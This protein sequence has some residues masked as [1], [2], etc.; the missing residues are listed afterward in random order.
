MKVVSRIEG[1]VPVPPEGSNV[2]VIAKLEHNISNESGPHKSLAEIVLVG[3]QPHQ[4]GHP[5]PVKRLASPFRG[6]SFHS[7][8]QRWRSRIKHGSKSEH[9]GYFCSDVEAAHAYN[10]AAKKIHGNNAQLNEGVELVISSHPSVS[11]SVVSNTRV[12]YDGQTVYMDRESK[13]KGRQ[14]PNVSPTT[15]KA[16]AV[17]VKSIKGRPQ[18]GAAHQQAAPLHRHYAHQSHVKR[19]SIKHEAPLD[20]YITAEDEPVSPCGNRLDFTAA[21]DQWDDL[22]L[23]YWFNDN[24]GP[25]AYFDNVD[26][27][28]G[29]KRVPSF[30][31]L[32][33][34]RIRC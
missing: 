11:T 24:A 1:L 18:F 32:E 8:T 9:L 15:K 14:A 22:F 12:P 19:D 4:Q 16:S 17:K 10:E 31:C 7:C 23:Q 26:D 25:L 21:I 6:V 30:A 29:V 13:N 3:D 20:F 2:V 27:R 33:P 28:C 5:G 34:K